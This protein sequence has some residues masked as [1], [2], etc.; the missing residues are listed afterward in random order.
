MRTTDNIRFILAVAMVISTAMA[1]EISFPFAKG[2]FDNNGKLQAWT[3][4]EVHL[5]RDN[6]IGKNIA[7]ANSTMEKDSAADPSFLGYTSPKPETITSEQPDPKPETI[8]PDPGLKY[9]SP[10][11]LDL[12]GE[13][14]SVQVALQVDDRA[15]LIVEEEL[16]GKEETGHVPFIETYEVMGTAL[17]NVQKSYKE[18]DKLIPTGRKYK[19][20]LEYR[21]TA[22]LTKQYGGIIDYDGINVFLI[23]EGPAFELTARGLITEEL[24]AQ[25]VPL[26]ARA[27]TNGAGTEADP[28]T[29]LTGMHYVV[30]EFSGDDNVGFINLKAFS[31]TELSS[32]TFAKEVVWTVDGGAGNFQ[33][34]ALGGVRE[35]TGVNVTFIATEPALYTFKA[36]TDGAS[37]NILVYVSGINIAKAPQYYFSDTTGRVPFEV[38]LLG[39]G[40]ENWFVDVSIPRFFS[41]QLRYQDNSLGFKTP[42]GF[43]GKLSQFAPTW[44]DTESKNGT[45]SSYKF[46]SDRAPM[47]QCVISNSSGLRQD[48]NVDMDLR[49]KLVLSREETNLA[50]L[51]TKPGSVKERRFADRRWAAIEIG[52][53]RKVVGNIKGSPGVGQYDHIVSDDNDF[54][55]PG[56]SQNPSTLGSAAKFVAGDDEKYDDP[57]TQRHYHQGDISLETGGPRGFDEDATLRGP[58]DYAVAGNTEPL[59]ATG[60]TF[61]ARLFDD[62]DFFSDDE[63]EYV[64]KA[65][66]GGIG[67]AAF[68]SYGLIESSYFGK[69]YDL[70]NLNGNVLP[71]ALP[72]CQWDL[73][74]TATQSGYVQYR[75][76]ALDIVGA[77]LS[78]ASAALLVAS[79]PPGWVAA[80]T[81]SAV[82]VSSLAVANDMTAYL[83]YNQHA[84]LAEVRPLS[85]TLHWESSS[86][87]IK[88]PTSATGIGTAILPFGDSG[89]WGIVETGGTGVTVGDSVR[90]GFDVFCTAQNHSDEIDPTPNVSGKVELKRASGNTNNIMD[91]KYEWK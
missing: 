47:S 5:H 12:T 35:K 83:A 26:E 39:A 75:G 76:V 22:N 54:E 1:E 36:T 86:L 8:T 16:T 21:N 57:L 25:G 69:Y 55:C 72:N 34:N 52:V 90:T 15:K 30:Q 9:F 89:V 50:W 64:A 53:D 81:W 11:V 24:I 73:T 3:L 17:W 78:V 77:G 29:L 19:L 37:K 66:G 45:S 59:S 62:G 23:K 6:A 33:G 27:A 79:G 88:P 63:E 74:L 38:D 10:T 32:Q 14:G 18:F 40:S 13:S 4:E 7:N 56:F 61:E 41:W 80:T 84:A 91:I 87:S 2:T 48:M 31:D 42:P 51:S 20:T 49:V 70:G 43:N 44:T 67:A 71:L 65:V 28:R 68:V 82:A 58:Q 85:G 46:V 60:S